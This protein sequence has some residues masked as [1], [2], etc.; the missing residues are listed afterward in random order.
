MSAATHEVMVYLAS[1]P[2][3][4]GF[5]EATRKMGDVVDVPGVARVVNRPEIAREILLD[6][7]HF[8]KSGPGSFGVLITQVM[9]ESALLN[10][11]GDA[12]HRLRARLQDLFAP[13]YLETIARDVLEAPVVDLGTRLE[14]GETVDLVRFMQLLTGRTTCHMLGLPAPAVGAGQTYFDLFAMVQQMSQSIGIATKKLT[15]AQVAAKKVPFERLTEAVAGAYKRDDLPPNSVLARLKDLGLCA[16]EAR[17]VVGMLLVVGTETMTTAV[18]RTVAL[19]VDSGQ[20]RDL[21]S[22]PN[23][24]QSAIDEALRFV[25]PSPIMLRSVSGDVTIAGHRFAAGQ[26][27]MLFTY[28]LLKH[29]DL[30]PRPRR[31]DIRR[32]QPACARNIW[33]GAGPHFCLGFGLAQREMRMVLGALMALPREIEVVRRAYARR[34]LIPG[35]ARLEVRMRQ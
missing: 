32:A 17:G 9:G 14:A 3:V 25:V 4:F 12:H 30:Y 16:D 21:R 15:P 35:Y 22:E 10:M 6:G 7:E 11:H 13:A 18:P 24:M 28:N 29:P 8:S 20:Q 19:L 26:R 31:F 1:H 33:F 2:V 27:V 34:V 5:A 23:L